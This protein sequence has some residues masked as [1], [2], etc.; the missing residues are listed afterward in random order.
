MQHLVEA[1]TVIWLMQAA[2]QLDIYA[3]DVADAKRHAA[4]ATTG[5]K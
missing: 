3:K 1:L 5:R 2:L 4:A